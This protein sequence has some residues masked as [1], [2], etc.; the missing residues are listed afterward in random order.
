MLRQAP[1]SNDLLMCTLDMIDIRKI[2]IRYS[3]MSQN[4]LK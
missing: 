2:T 3:Y 4:T 1:P